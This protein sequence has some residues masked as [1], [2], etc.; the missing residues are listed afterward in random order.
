MLSFNSDL[1][2]VTR[3]K[4]AFAIQDLPGLWRIH[5][6]LFGITIL[7][8]FYTRHDQACLLWGVL[9]A[10]IFMM[11]QFM[12][13][14]WITQALL[15]SVLTLI[16]MAGMLCLTWYFTKIPTLSWILYGWTGLMGTGI[17]LTDLG[18][19]LGW[20]Q[21]LMHICPLWL[22]LSAIGYG[23]MGVGMRSRAFLLV[24]LL[25]LITIGLLPYLSPWQPL[26]T[27]LV[28]SGSVFLIAELQWDADEA[29]EHHNLLASSPPTPVHQNNHAC[30]EARM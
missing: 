26:T 3:K 20:G 9:S 7:S 2:I 12:A 29:C 18:I 28:I 17:L 16:G 21:I 6:Q 13:L 1:P 10:I 25:H 24:S 8:T 14:S 15:A 19:F 11:A 22:G 27:G 5:W 30:I 23:A 4:S